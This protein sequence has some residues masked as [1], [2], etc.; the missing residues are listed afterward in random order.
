VEENLKDIF[1]NLSGDISQE[2]LIKY[3][4]GKL[5]EEEK[6]EVEKKMLSSDFDYDALEGLKEL[7]DKRKI[8]IIVG[9]INRELRRKLEQKKNRSEKMKL[10]AHPW[11]YITLLV[12]LALIILAYFVIHNMLR[13]G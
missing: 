12:I 5:T 2:T 9:Q 6:H 1:A 13:D 3:L 11:L 7:K 4:E 10:K 8:S